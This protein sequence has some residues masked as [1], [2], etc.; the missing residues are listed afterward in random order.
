MRVTAAQFRKSATRSRERK[1][2]KYGAQRV[3]VDGIWFDSKR[4]A[5]R[6]LQLKL[7]V[8]AGEISDLKRQVTVKLEGRDGPLLTRT[9]RR[10]RY[11]ADFTY[12]DLKTGLTIYEDA[13]GKPT[14]EYNVKRAVAMAQ[15]VELREV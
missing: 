10:M 4:E 8:R 11:I 13:K 7:M 12:T 9:G 3:H 15:G 5:N 14:P 6:W 1:P 2:N